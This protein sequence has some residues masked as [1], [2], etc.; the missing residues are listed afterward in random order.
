MKTA[1]RDFDSVQPASAQLHAVTDSHFAHV[2][3]R[4]TLQQVAQCCQS[5]KLF[6]FRN[7][8][9]LDHNRFIDMILLSSRTTLFVENFYSTSIFHA[10]LMR[11]RVK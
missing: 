5:A 4:L 2:R 7:S 8:I 3:N 11:N 1:G 6:Y 9:N 10:L